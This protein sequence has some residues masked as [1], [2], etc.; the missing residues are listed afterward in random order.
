MM[1]GSFVHS[2]FGTPAGEE[3]CPERSS[4]ESVWA[5]H[6]GDRPWVAQPP[7]LKPQYRHEEATS[8][9]QLNMC[10]SQSSPHTIR[11][12]PHETP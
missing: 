10:M 5:A 8:E 6:M 2:I 1:R 11:S 4:G 9:C 3:M 7:Q 12:Q